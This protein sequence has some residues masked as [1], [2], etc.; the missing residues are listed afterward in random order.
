[1]LSPGKSSGVRHV[2]VSSDRAGQRLDNFLSAQLKGL[3]K[4][5][6]YKMI[7]TGQV[8]INGRRCKPASRLQ[9]G[10]AVRIPPARVRED[11]TITVS[12]RVCSQVRASVLFQDEDLMVINKPSGMAV[13]SGSGLPWGLI[14]VVR[15]IHPGEYFELA[16]RLD[17]QTSGCLVLARNGRSLNHLTRLFREGGVQK[18][19]LCLLDG[20]MA[21]AVIEVDAALKKDQSGAEREVIVSED[22]KAALTRFQ[23][24][25]AWRDCSY[26]E[27]QLLTGRT[28]Q[29]RVHALHMGMPLAGDE[30]YAGRES[31]EKWKTRG[32]QRTFLHAHR[33]AFE[34][35]SGEALQFEAPLPETLKAVLNRCEA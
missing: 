23:L 3:P 34:A 8:R 4:S 25:E 29:I 14:D 28:H 22:G 17:R 9:E 30:K 15:Q 19:Y 10:D 20:R 11:G 26:A 31:G 33:L 21:E 32:L 24:L 18:Y 6:I 2:Q 16:H 27:A 1:M 5:A 35:L 12:D 13:H 7:R